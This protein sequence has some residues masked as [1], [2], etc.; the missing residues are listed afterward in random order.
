M[1]SL[2]TKGAECAISGSGKDPG[3]K[4]EFFFFP[5]LNTFKIRMFN[6][7]HIV[8]FLMNDGR[9]YLQQTALITDDPFIT[10]LLTRLV[11]IGKIPVIGQ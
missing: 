8:K 6:I 4:E 1:F 11:V 10:D 3:I 7:N 9:G 2:E 5:D